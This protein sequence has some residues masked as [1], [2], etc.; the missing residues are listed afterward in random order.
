MAWYRR[1]N[2]WWC[3]LCVVLLAAGCG[4]P[5]ARTQQPARAQRPAAEAPPRISQAKAG[6]WLYRLQMTSARTG[7]AL[8]WTVNPFGTQA[9]YLALARTTDGAR[10]WT[11][12]T[13]PA[14]AALLGTPGATP[15]LDALDGNRAWLAV[16]EAPG[17]TSSP[18][19]TMVFGTSDGGRTWTGSAP[20]KVPA[21]ARLLDFAGPGD[22]WLAASYG[23]TM[24]QDPVWLYRT[25]DAGLRWS[26]VAA[27]PRSGTGSNGLPVECDKAGLAFATAQA[28]WLTSYCIGES[29]DVLLVTRDGGA[30]WAP[31]ALPVPASAFCSSGCEVY[32]PPQ[33][34]GRTGFVVIGHGPAAPYFL[35]SH[36]L[37]ESWA[38]QPLPSG[39]GVY[40]RITFFSPLDGV[41]VS[42]GPQGAIGGT[43][44]TTADGGT[45]WTAVPQG[46]SFT[47][48]GTAFDFVSPRTGFAWM[49]GADAPAGPPAMDQTTDSGRTWTVFTPV[50]ADG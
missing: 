27:A 16:T 44:D 26:L 3:A 41:L 45:T 32:N 24:G 33:F 50:L 49:P 18:H 46:R 15:V 4:S 19:L 1:R 11:D 37:G 31:Q 23:G 39:A 9:G 17:K 7:W 22:G 47:A 13:P 35:A 29:P 8:R 43:F 36:D 38:P 20:F 34:F 40:P 5:A 6:I 2:I 25:T 21:P 12:V 42:A 10:T 14:A 48:N 30:R 28:G